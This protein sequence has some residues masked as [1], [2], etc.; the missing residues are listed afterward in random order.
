MSLVLP[1]QT[2]NILNLSFI[3][4]L[5][6]KEKNFSKIIGPLFFP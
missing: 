6:G 5:L 2:A 4:Y 3:D 1:G